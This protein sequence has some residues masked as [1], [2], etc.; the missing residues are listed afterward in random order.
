MTN[1]LPFNYSFMDES[2]SNVYKAEQR[3]G[4]I[5]FTFSLLAIVIA[6]LGLFGLATFLAEQKTKE[7]GI[8]KVLGASIP[9]LLFML[10][11]E[12]LKWILIANLIA[13]PI[14][15]YF[16]NAWLQDYAYRV[17]ISFWTFII[18]G[19]IALIVAIATVSF[20]AIK[21][22]TA[23]PVDSLRYE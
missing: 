12:F 22:A 23:N 8:R 14:S 3:V 20:Q 18:S 1:G 6:C 13:W 9:S 5:S 15:Y 19:G 2:F 10:L 21:A 17:E 4:K 11:K 7:V 16:M